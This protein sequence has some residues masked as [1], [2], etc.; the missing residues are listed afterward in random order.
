MR[1]RILVLDNSIAMTGALV[2]ALRSSKVLSDKFEFLFMLPS[3]SQ[4]TSAVR[5]EGFSVVE[6]PMKELSRNPVS[7]LLYLPFLLVNTFKLR[8]HIKDHR[9]DLVLGNDFYNLLPAALRMSG[10]AIPYVVY[11]RF[12]PDRFPP[13]L[14]WLW[15]NVHYVF[16]KRVVAVSFAVKNRLKPARKLVVIHNELPV[17]VEIE[18]SRPGHRRLLFLA[19]Y[20][21]GKGQR[22]ALESF[23]RL[24]DKFSEWTLR[25]VGSDMNLSK[26][27]R[28]R[29]QLQ[30]LSEKLGLATRVEWAGFTAE[31]RSEYLAAGIVLNLSDSESFSMT[32]LEAMFYG[33]CIVSTRSGGPEEIIDHGRTGLLVPKGDVDGLTAELERVMSDEQLRCDIA[34]NAFEES[35]KKFAISHTVAKLEQVYL[36][37]LPRIKS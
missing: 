19:N 8:S 32:C 28:Y 30:E 17:D 24:K 36:D 9:V 12:M 34:R 7:W 37:S 1:K 13:I 29:K 16:S 21:P 4:A 31:V 35:R 14:V 10:S 15:L 20:I 3:G 5:D 6:L 33:R 23:A 27:A 18:F 26:N 25:F 22:M 11:I 2:S